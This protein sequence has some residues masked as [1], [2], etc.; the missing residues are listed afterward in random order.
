[1]LNKG[2]NH[3][4]GV[5]CIALLRY[6]PSQLQ[7]FVDHDLQPVAELRVRSANDASNNS[8]TRTS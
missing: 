3:F 5:V 8:M 4:M 1:M 7:A 2:Q 6:P